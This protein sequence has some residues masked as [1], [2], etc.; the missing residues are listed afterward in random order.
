MREVIIEKNNQYR[1]A[2]SKDLGGFS[3]FLFDV[4]V[5]KIMVGDE[6]NLSEKEQLK[7]ERLLKKHIKKLWE[8]RKK[9]ICILKCSIIF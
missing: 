3:G 1:G 4:G 8:R 2:L 6:G 9:K 7:I 5:K